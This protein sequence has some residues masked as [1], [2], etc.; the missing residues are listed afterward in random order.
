MSDPI[1]PLAPGSLS[2]EHFQALLDGTRIS[3]EKTIDAL[4]DHLVSGMSSLEVIKKHGVA[5]SH[6]YTRL[7]LIR[8]AHEYGARISQFYKVVPIVTIVSVGGKGAT[9]S[10]GT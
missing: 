8:S 9:D 5:K 1:E 3:G 7:K 10:S 4:R 2:V 6:F